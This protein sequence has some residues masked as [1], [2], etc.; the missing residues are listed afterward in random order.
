MNGIY[1]LMYKLDKIGIFWFNY[2][3]YFIFKEVRMML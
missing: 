1:Y 2:D 3:E